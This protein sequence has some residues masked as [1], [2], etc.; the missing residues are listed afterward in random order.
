[1]LPKRGK[2]WRGLTFWEWPGIRLYLGKAFQLLAVGFQRVH[3]GL[4][5]L[6]F[7]FFLKA[8]CSLE[9]GLG[10]ERVHL[11]LQQYFNHASFLLIFC[12]LCSLLSCFLHLCHYVLNCFVYA[13]VLEKRF[14]LPDS[15]C[16]Y[17]LCP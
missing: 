1:M 12:F 4:Q 16:R 17:L 14:I 2:T 13:V 3:R 9:H 8:G 10:F 11:G 6:L 5:Q 15:S 7:M